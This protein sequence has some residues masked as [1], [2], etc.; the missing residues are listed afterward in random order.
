MNNNI[1]KEQPIILKRK[2]ENFEDENNYQNK[3]NKYFNLVW[4]NIY[5]RKLI[6]YYLK[7]YNIFFGIRTFDSVESLLKFKNKEYLSQVIIDNS[8]KKDMVRTNAKIPSWIQ[9]IHIPSYYDQSILKDAYNLHTLCIY[10]NEC[11]I[12]IPPN[13]LPASITDLKLY[14]YTFEILQDVLPKNLKKFSYSVRNNN[15][16]T[17]NSLPD[18]LLELTFHLQIINDQFPIKRGFLP[19]GLLTLNFD[20]IFDLELPNDF[21]L[22]PSLTSLNIKCKELNFKLP[23]TLKI[24]TLRVYRSFIKENAL[25]S[26]LEH[27]SISTLIINDQ[28]YHYQQLS[29]KLITSNITSLVL[30]NNTPIIDKFG[31]SILPKCLKSLSFRN[32]NERLLPWLLPKGLVNLNFQSTFA[33]F[34]NAGYPLIEDNIF[35]NSLK[36]INFGASYNQPIGINVLPRSGNLKTVIFGCCFSQIIHP[37]SIPSSV[38]L[39]VIKNSNY[40][41][42]IVLSNNPKT[43]IKCENINRYIKQFEHTPEQLEALA[44]PVFFN[45]QLSCLSLQNFVNLKK[46]I[47]DFEFNQE[48]LEKD[49][50]LNNRIQ[51]L[52]LGKEFNKVLYLDYFKNLECLIINGANPTLQ[53]TITT[54]QNN[55]DENGDVGETKTYNFYSLK[56]IEVTIDTSTKFLDNLDPMYYQ[57]IKLIKKHNSKL[58]YK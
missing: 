53:T 27:L 50:P 26:S 58:K 42:P 54:L 8:I 45:A 29:H 56:V 22:P 38:E 31:I 6:L 3:L 13:T 51:T 5:L 55:D 43:L 9:L 7:V 11:T 36:Y 4:K 39:L 44:L 30:G 15:T 24:L 32:C 19:K 14:G 52:E 25:P 34:D 41:H 16:I 28:I 20:S 23:P 57:F 48:I 2:R 35:P 47:F 18:S 40:E 37:D 49:L 1:E 17:E 33:S 12:E 46:L 21:E 10:G